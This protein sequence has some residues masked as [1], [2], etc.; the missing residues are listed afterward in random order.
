MNYR[1]ITAAIITNL[2]QTERNM[3]GLH[4]RGKQKE[5]DLLTMHLRTVKVLAAALADDSY[6]AIKK[7][8]EEE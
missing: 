2:N 6:T 4:D 8:L 3:D 7:Y 5:I 1:Q